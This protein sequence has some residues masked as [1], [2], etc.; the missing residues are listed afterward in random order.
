VA[1]IAQIDTLQSW[2]LRVGADNVI[3]RAA[4]AVVRLDHHSIG[5]RHAVV[6]HDGSGWQVEDLRST[7]G[8]WWSRGNEW[9]RVARPTL[10]RSGDKLRVGSVELLFVDDQGAVAR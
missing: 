2:P 1:A 3:G 10:L 6:R 7:G 8:T 4:D 5:R 9:Q